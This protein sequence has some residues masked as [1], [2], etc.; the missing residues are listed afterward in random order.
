M[1]RR[2]LVRLDEV[3]LG[4]QL[5]SIN[6]KLDS[7]VLGLYREATGS[8]LSTQSTEGLKLPRVSL[9]ALATMALRT[10][11]K[12]CSLPRGTVHASQ[13]ICAYREVIVGETLTCKTQVS[14]LHRRREVIL[15]SLDLSVTDPKGT[16]VMWQKI[17]VMFP[18]E[19]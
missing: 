18:K 5:P 15:L 3:G 9:S 11:L 2:E 8:A 7:A 12:Q 6:F 16:E 10:L 1:S 19:G 13:E 14:G 4:Q 17:I